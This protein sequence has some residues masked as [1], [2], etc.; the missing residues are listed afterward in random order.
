[1][2]DLKKLNQTKSNL[3]ILNQNSIEK[4]K[5]FNYNIEDLSSWL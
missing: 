2:K 4:V 3:K 5:K 1:M